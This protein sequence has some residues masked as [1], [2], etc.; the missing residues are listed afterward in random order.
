MQQ[1]GEIGFRPGF[2]VLLKI[3]RFKPQTEVISVLSVD[4]LIFAVIAVF[5]ILRLRSVLGTR[6][7]D[8]RPRI[9]PFVAPSA[10]DAGENGLPAQPKDRFIFMPSENVTALPASPLNETLFNIAAA[11]PGFDPLSFRE[12]AAEAY[13]MIVRAFAA[14]DRETLRPLLSDALFAD[15]NRA[16]SEREKAGHTSEAEVTYI[17]HS[18]ITEAK[19]ENGTAYVTV[20]F[21]AEERAVT[22]DAGGNVISGSADDV[23]DMIDIWTF[24]R[25]L[26]SRDPNWILTA[27]RAT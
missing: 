16:I 15:F 3:A 17:K 21:T 7:G 10:N 12:G 11:T 1:S 23:E 6:H 27:T 25:S 8:E 13:K 5:L 14:G 18:E 4:L 2:D 9:N 19:I 20:E 22:R 26:N 24:A